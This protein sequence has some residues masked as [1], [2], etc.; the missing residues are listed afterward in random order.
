MEK[1]ITNNTCPLSLLRGL[2]NWRISPFFS[3]PWIQSLS[4][5]IYAPEGGAAISGEDKKHGGRGIGS[6]FKK[7]ERLVSSLLGHLSST[8]GNS[9][10]GWTIFM[11]DPER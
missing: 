8:R 2:Q 5:F 10:R 1:C 6:L 7:R 4:S 11:A 9:F 3:V